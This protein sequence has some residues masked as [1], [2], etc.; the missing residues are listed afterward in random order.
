M[1]DRRLVLAFADAVKEARQPIA[2]SPSRTETA[3]KI[4]A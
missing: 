4:S 3:R 2:A 1:P